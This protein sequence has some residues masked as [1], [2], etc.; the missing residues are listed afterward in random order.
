MALSPFVGRVTAPCPH[1]LRHTMH[2]AMRRCCSATPRQ[3][4]DH[5]EKKKKERYS[6]KKITK[7]QTKR[8]RKETEQ[9]RKKKDKR[10]RENN[11]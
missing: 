5:V 10:T 7:N 1:L 9:E 6:K 4:R 11:R 2:G 8:K 3:A